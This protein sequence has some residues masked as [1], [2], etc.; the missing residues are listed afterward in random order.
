MSETPDNVVSIETRLNEVAPLEVARPEWDA[1]RH[2][3]IW[4]EESLRTCTCR[5]CGAE[6]VDPFDVLVRLARKWSRWQREAEQLRTLNR[7]YE[8]NQKARWERARDRHLNAHPEHRARH[9][10]G[11]PDGAVV[12]QQYV[13]ARDQR[14]RQ[15]GYGIGITIPQDCRQCGSLVVGFDSRWLP[16]RAPEPP[17]GKL[18][19]A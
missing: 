1:C 5:D 15:G 6:R 11:L 9:F 13:A 14:A 18:D 12:P 2:E 16:S 17:P 7:E 10:I 8:D 3:H 4:L 19:P